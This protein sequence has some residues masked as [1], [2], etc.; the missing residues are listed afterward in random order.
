MYQPKY[1]INNEILKNIGAIEACREV[2]EHSPLIPSYEKKFQDDAI[3]RT[4]YHGTHL[5]GNDL[6]LTQAQKVFEGEQ[7]LAR[8]RDIQEVINY[9][10]AMRFL[11]SINKPLTY[12]LDLLCRLHNLTTERILASDD[13]GKIRKTQVVIKDSESGEVIFRPPPAIEVPFLLADFFD[14]LNSSEG[15]EVHSVLRAGITHYTLV[16]IHPYVE[17]NGRVSRAF[18]TLILFAEGYDIKKLFSIEEYFDKD[19]ASY[20]EA[21]KKVDEGG[22]NLNERDLTPW[23]AFFTRGLSIE[24]ERVRDQVRRISADLQIKK[25]LGQQVALSPRQL[26]LMEYFNEHGVLQMRTA[27]KL[28]AMVSEDTIL[29]ELQDL[30]KQGIIKKE[31]HGRGAIYRIKF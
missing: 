19:A 31:S 4:V 20:Y 7:I 8:D 15:K 14:W 27:K 17:G 30:V 9:R 18:A 12:T 16:A 29:R 11:D 23:L 3:F 22:I 2:I 28:L 24:L 21:I 5:E 13:S 26:K 10:N 1:I 25:R 6:T